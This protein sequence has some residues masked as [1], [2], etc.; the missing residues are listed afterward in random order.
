VLLTASETPQT[1]YTPSAWGGDCASDGT[2]TLLPGDNKTCTITNDDI[3]PIL[4]I[5]KDAEPNDCQD[6]EF[7]MTDQSNFY[8]DDDT[9]VVGCMDT[10]RP[11]SK[12]FDDLMAGQNYTVIEVIPNE[13][14]ELYDVS[15]VVTGSATPYPFTSVTNGLEIVLSLADDVTCTFVNEKESPTR[16]QGFWKTHTAY[17]SLIF[18]TYFGSGMTIGVSPHK[19]TIHNVQSSGQSELFGAYYANIAKISTGK[20]KAAKRNPVDQARMQLLR[21]LVTA[22]LNCAAFGCQSSVQTLITQADAAYAGGDKNL[23]LYYA[24]ELDEYNNSGDTII[25]VGDPGNAT[26]QTSKDWADIGF[27]DSP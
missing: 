11:Q 13:Y 26:P 17:T 21:Q 2:I 15:C 20:G 18:S 27:W 9:D 12:T 25:L 10:D 22:K 6:F 24:G 19:G 3:A 14:W 23:I 16:T 8:L 7:S 1:G 5:V 4:T